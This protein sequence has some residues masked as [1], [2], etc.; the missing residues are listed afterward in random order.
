MYAIRSYY[1]DVLRSLTETLKWEDELAS[2]TRKVAMYPAFVGTIVIAATFFLMT[3]MVPQLKL[4][5]RNM[6]QEMPMQTKVLF[7]VSDLLVA[8]WYVAL[9]APLIAFIAV[10]RITSYNVC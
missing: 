10:R 6:G 1:A 3:Y 2:Q 4:F 7:F 8:Y 9:I 5:V